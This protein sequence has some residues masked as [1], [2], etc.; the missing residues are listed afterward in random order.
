[1]MLGLL[2]ATILTFGQQAPARPAPFT[3]PELIGNDWLKLGANK[4]AK[5]ADLRG[6]VVVLH[7]FTSGCINCKR[8][9]A[10]YGRLAR[11]F[12]YRDFQMIGIHSPEFPGE[13]EPSAIEAVMKKYDTDFPVL[14]DPKLENWKAWR[15][16]WWPTVYVIDK[17]GKVRFKWAGELAWQGAD[18]ENQLIRAV[19]ELLK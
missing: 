4:P 16:E 14:R 10:A 18:G 12:A 15:Q 8:N 7:F 11:K 2:A 19:Q 9:L 1:M 13:N 3:A 17:Q 6:K 5:L